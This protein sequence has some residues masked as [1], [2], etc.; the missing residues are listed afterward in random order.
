MNANTVIVYASKHHGNTKKLLEAI[1]EQEDVELL[2]LAGKDR[3][4]IDDSI[5]DLI[6][7]LIHSSYLH[8]IDALLRGRTDGNEL[9]AY[10]AASTQ[11]LMPLQRCDDEYLSTFPPHA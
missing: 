5:N 2:D 11:E 6:S 7:C 10:I 8:D 3:V 9:T 1:A 4:L